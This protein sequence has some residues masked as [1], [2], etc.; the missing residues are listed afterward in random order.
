MTIEEM[1][2]VIKKFIE[3]NFYTDAGESIYNKRCNTFD[4]D[5]DRIKEIYDEVIS[6]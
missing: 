2:S 4:D 6:Y 5:Y 1:D 3:E